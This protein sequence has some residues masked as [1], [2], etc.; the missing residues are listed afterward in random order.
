[1]IQIDF[2]YSDPIFCLLKNDS[3][4]QGEQTES[5]LSKG[6]ERTFRRLIDF[7]LINSLTRVTN[8]S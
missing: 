8:M 5:V 7:G 1:L 3:N 2:I 6:K 4:L